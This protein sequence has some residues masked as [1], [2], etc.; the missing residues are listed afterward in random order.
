[1]TQI[2]EW[3][4]ATYLLESEPVFQTVVL[5]DQGKTEYQNHT[6]D[7]MEALR[8]HD[9]WVLKVKSELYKKQLS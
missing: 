4:I 8:D 6:R 9:A 2:D 3:L 1:V 7:R 5:D